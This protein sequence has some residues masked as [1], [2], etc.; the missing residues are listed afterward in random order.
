MSLE[1]MK[2]VAKAELDAKKLIADEKA[3]AK[4]AAEDAAEAGRKKHRRLFF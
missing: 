4:T 1:S 2:V 3:Q